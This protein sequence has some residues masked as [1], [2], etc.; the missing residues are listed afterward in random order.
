VARTVGKLPS[1]APKR[2]AETLGADSGRDERVRS[3]WKPN[4]R[5]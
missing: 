1:P 2:K 5:P 3:G 4:W